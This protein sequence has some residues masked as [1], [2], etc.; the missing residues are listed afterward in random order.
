MLNV[1]A[2]DMSTGRRT[3]LGLA[4][5]LPATPPPY[6]SAGVACTSS[7]GIPHE[8]RGT[9]LMMAD[10]QPLPGCFPSSPL[11]FVAWIEA[12]VP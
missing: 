1:R 6:S 11:A 4:D 2:A 7:V 8:S 12:N 5:W 3:M 9:K 10:L